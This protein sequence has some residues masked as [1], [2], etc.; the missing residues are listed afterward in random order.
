MSRTPEA[1]LPTESPCLFPVTSPLGELHEVNMKIPQRSRL[2][3]NILDMGKFFLKI[4]SLVE[5]AAETRPKT[6]INIL[7]TLFIVR[8]LV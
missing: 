2:T 6:P 5:Y 4:F 1:K 3:G 8:L 7:V